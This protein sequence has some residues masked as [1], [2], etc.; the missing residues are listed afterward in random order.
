MSEWV[1]P[2]WAN[3]VLE[4]FRDD[5]IANLDKNYDLVYVHYDDKFSD[6]Q[7]A[8]LIAGDWDKLWEHNDQ[9]EDEARWHGMKYALDEAVKETER[10]WMNLYDTDEFDVGQVLSDFEMSDEEEAVRDQIYER[11]NGNWPKELARNTGRVLCRVFLSETSDPTWSCLPNLTPTEVVRTIGLKRREQNKA[12]YKIVR[13]ILNEAFHTQAHLAPMLV[14][15]LDVDDV[16]D[17]PYDTEYVDIVNP[18]L[19]LGNP[20][21]GDGMCGDEALQ[22]TFRIKREDLRTDEDAPGYSW[23]QVAGPNVRYYEAEIRPVKNRKVA[24]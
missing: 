18:F 22:A 17:I 2:R 23:T 1:P 9:W 12:N 5:V 10:E 7:V 8:L 24:V 3:T 14:F 21:E 16:F 20:Y 11:D 19:W 6:E 15:A 13:E 4:Q